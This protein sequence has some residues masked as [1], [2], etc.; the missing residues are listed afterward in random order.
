MIVV[1][2]EDIVSLLNIDTTQIT[3]ETKNALITFG[4]EYVDIT[5]LEEDI[6]CPYKT[7]DAVKSFRRRKGNAKQYRNC[8]EE[9]QSLTQVLEENNASYVRIIKL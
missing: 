8:L 2:K 1:K 4:K 7:I 9:L 3:E 5:S 6:Y